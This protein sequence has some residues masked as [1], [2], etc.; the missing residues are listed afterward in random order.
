MKL[1]QRAYLIFLVVLLSSLRV[2]GQT[3]IKQPHTPDTAAVY[4]LTQLYLHTDKSVYVHNENI[5][6]AGYLLKTA[7]SLDDYHTLYV[8]LSNRLTDSI[9][10]TEKFVLLKGFAA[11]YL[12]LPDSI[13]PGDYNLLA[14]TNL[15]GRESFPAV[16]QQ[17]ISLRS[18]KTEPFSISFESN[19]PNIVKDSCSFMARVSTADD[20]YAEGATVDYTVLAD[21][22][23]IKKATA[24]INQY[25][26]MPV[27]FSLKPGAAK[28]ELE[29]RVQKDKRS[30]TLRMPVIPLSNRVSFRWFPESGDLINGIRSKVAFEAMDLAGK[31]VALEGYLLEDGKKINRIQ[32]N[33]A[34]LGATELTPS[35][36]STYSFQPDDEKTWN[37]GIN[38]P[39][40]K[41]AGYVMSVADG[42]VKDSIAVRIHSTE[43]KKQLV[44]L[45]HTMTQEIGTWKLDMQKDFLTV[46]I[47]L[48]GL[49]PGL[50]LL[51]LMDDQGVLLAERA[52]I[53]GYDRRPVA[54]LTADAGQYSKRSAVKVKVKMTDNDGNPVKA[55]FSSSCVLRSRIDPANFQ[56]IVAYYYFNEYMQA[57]LVQKA[58]LAGLGTKDDL[59]MFLLTKCWS[60][61]RQRMDTT[62]MNISNR[63]PLRIGGVVKTLTK[64]AKLPVELSVIQKEGLFFLSTD[65]QGRFELPPDMTML[66]PDTKLQL[67]VNTKFKNEYSIV[68]D[69]SPEIDQYLSHL[70]FPDVSVVKAALPA[71]EKKMLNN[72]KTLNK[73][74]VKST[75][76][77]QYAS[78]PYVSKVCDDYV[79]MYNILNCPNH[80]HGAPAI[81]G[82]T[83]LVNGQPTLYICES[84]QNNNTLLY[85][86]KGRYYTKE[87]YVADYS[88]FNPP[89]PETLSTIYWSPQTMTDDKGEY[90]LNFYTNDLPGIYTLIVEGVYDAGVISGST[91]FSVLP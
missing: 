35:S 21:D 86:F 39:E 62:W 12:F 66:Q 60:R 55:V 6:F 44:L 67:V 41:Q 72:V 69:Q 36:K 76:K 38:F 43:K 80:P 18:A 16:Y 88:K 29:A 8:C 63:N 14:Y 37:T 11:G 82:N 10:A 68:L 23:A 52:I 87:F 34:G 57:G 42:V 7:F 53:N 78:P 61:Y 65:A 27:S 70:S 17:Q 26:E 31:P 2:W 74:V 45:A 22:Q 77:D 24:R 58:S 73:V 56:D 15:L 1:L 51:T 3:G 13:P 83:Y 91:I 81:S 32:T 19:Q 64:K 47:R 84:Q 49:E 5:W 30:H 40:V 33:A 25:G 46:K 9:V 90:E 20:H 85:Q 48:P 79:C 28:Y 50:L 4:G 71:E 75:P 59:E 89:E 54:K